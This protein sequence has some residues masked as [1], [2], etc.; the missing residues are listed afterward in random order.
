MR[1]RAARPYADR[2][3]FTWTTTALLAA[4]LAAP[5]RADVVTVVPGESI[6]DAID[7]PGTVDGDEIV[8]APG[9]YRETIDFGGRAITVRSIAPDDPAVVARTVIDGDGAGPVITCTGG[10]GPDSRLAG[11]T[12]RGGV[13]LSGGGMLVELS[14]P[15][16]VRCTFVDNEAVF[17][18]GGMFCL[19]GNP[20]VIDCRFVGNRAFYGGGISVIDAS[21]RFVD[22]VFA[23]NEAVATGGGVDFFNGGAPR[24]AGCV[25]TANTAGDG[26]GLSCEDA[27]ATI[28]NTIV[29]A[30]A[31]DLNASVRVAGTVVG[32]FQYSDVAGSGG[33]A[34]WDPAFGS[35]G[36]GNIDVDPRF[37]DAAGADGVAG[38]LDDDL[39]PA[40]DSRVI[41]AGRNDAIQ[42]DFGD[43]DGDGDLAEPTPL[44][45]DGRPRRADV[46]ATPDTGSGASPLVDMGP[47]EAAAASTCPWD[48][49]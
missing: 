29:S 7:A 43:L 9:V 16:V 34:E 48:L 30:N 8:I 47:Y 17:E 38:T 27:G 4:M 5:A 32:T 44:D 35:D 46:A 20:S 10:E 3:A 36:G 13:G 41:D 28:Y 33:S 23:G 31:A 1:E 19:A 49:T 37:T 25:V 18:G 2:S 26:G 12:I 40:P 22:C 24:L 11:L 39:R 6:Q 45:L 21:P 14:A 42:A 15:T